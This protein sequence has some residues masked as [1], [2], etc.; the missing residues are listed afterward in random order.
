MGS[1]VLTQF[2]LSYLF[3]NFFFFLAGEGFGF[4]ILK[5]FVSFCCST[6][7]GISG[8][9]WIHVLPLSCARSPFLKFRITFTNR[10]MRCDTLLLYVCH[11]LH[12]P[13]I[14]REHVS[15]R[16]LALLLAAESDTLFF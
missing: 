12:L 16:M 2:F 10:S 5:F 13:E 8:F 11:F 9:P 3:F 14:Q 15:F 6:R 7:D 1:I 4:F